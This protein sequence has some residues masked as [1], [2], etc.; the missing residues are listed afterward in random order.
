MADRPFASRPDE[1]QNE[2]QLNYISRVPRVPRSELTSPL[3]AGGSTAPA[4]FGAGRRRTPRPGF[5]CPSCPSSRIER[6]TW[7][8]WRRDFADSKAGDLELTV[9]ELAAVFVRL[10]LAEILETQPRGARGRGYIRKEDR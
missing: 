5:A 9:P 8:V 3:P 10:G 2:G 4:S 6:G 1:G 7:I